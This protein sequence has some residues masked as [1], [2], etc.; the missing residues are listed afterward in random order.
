MKKIMPRKEIVALMASGAVLLCMGGHLVWYGIT[1]VGPGVWQYDGRDLGERRQA[2]IS[3]HTDQRECYGTAG[4]LFLIGGVML[5]RR[6]AEWK[7]GNR[8]GKSWAQTTLNYRPR[9]DACWSSIKIRTEARPPVIAALKHWREWGQAHVQWT[10]ERIALR[11][12][13]RTARHPRHHGRRPC[14]TPSTLPHSLPRRVTLPPS[15][16]H[17]HPAHACNRY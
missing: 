6:I 10:V 13:E 1:H 5:W 14:G 11:T 16:H 15:P 8:L 17:R 7:E 3:A 9:H 4:V 12:V 2:M